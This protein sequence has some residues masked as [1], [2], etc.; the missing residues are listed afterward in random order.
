MMFLSD[1]MNDPRI[2]GKILFQEDENAHLPVHWHDNVEI[3][4]FL[5]GGFRVQIDG[6]FYDVHNND[7][8]M[9]NS[10]QMH[11]WGRNCVGRY[12]GITLVADMDFWE[13]ICPNLNELEFDF[14]I[15]PE[16]VPTLKNLMMQLYETSSDYY[17][18]KMLHSESTT[19]GK[20]LM[21]LHGLVCM[22][23]YMLTTYFSRPRSTSPYSRIQIQKSNLQDVVQYINT[24]YTEH[25]LLK[26]V[27]EIHNISCEHL[28][29]IFKKSLGM[30]FKEYLN[31][32]RLNHACKLMIHTNLGTLEIATEAGFPDLR[33]FGQQFDRVYHMTP[34]EFRKKYHIN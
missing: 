10:G 22:I 15:C 2:P 5:Q 20:E 14:A 27:A 26:D 17:T 18:A 28:A 1:K 29:R 13:N 3:A 4:F 16:Q 6:K 24:H 8:F 34:K 32:V 23:Y 19:S 21:A 33:S 11:L 7:L 31:T 30:T 25:L 9:V 12:K